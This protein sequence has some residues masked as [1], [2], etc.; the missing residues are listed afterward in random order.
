MALWKE[1]RGY[2]GLY[3]ISDEGEV[4]SLPRTI[5]TKNHS[6]DIV[7]HRKMKKLK[8]HLRGND[9]L[10]YPAVTLSKNGKSIAYSLHRLVA[11][12]FIPNPDN[13]PEVNHIDENTMNCSVD[14]LEW[15]DHQYN[16][17]YSKSNR[18][19]Q[20]LDGE[21]IAEYKSIAYASKITGISR[22]N[23]NNVLA[24]WSKSAGGFKWKYS[25]EKKGRE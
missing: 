25:D 12:A 15:C 22:T 8:P 9:G 5:E 24:G 13:L 20:Y 19:E 1:I 6:G 3:L 14:N 17:D 11:T 16:V 7:V 23:I 2:E 18:I 21:K 4:I 10:K